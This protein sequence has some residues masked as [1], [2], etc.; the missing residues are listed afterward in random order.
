MRRIAIAGCLVLAACTG[1]PNVKGPDVGAPETGGLEAAVRD[2]VMVLNNPNGAG[3]TLTL[4]LR[5]GGAGI[6]ILD[7]SGRGGREPVQWRTMGDQLCLT[8]PAN[9]LMSASGAEEC[10]TASVGPNRATLGTRGSGFVISGTV[11]PL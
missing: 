6:L 10:I 8:S 9:G 5:A 11:A 7:E 1:L 2:K 3:G 4:Q